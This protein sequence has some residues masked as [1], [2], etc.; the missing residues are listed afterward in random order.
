MMRAGNQSSSDNEGDSARSTAKKRSVAA[1]N[2]LFNNDWEEQYFFVCI[3]NKPVCLVC[4]EAVSVFKACNL[5]RHYNT[6][7]GQM[8]HLG[9]SYV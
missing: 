5:Q 4:R 1:E 7:H 6:K 3:K 9:V 8:S 2:R